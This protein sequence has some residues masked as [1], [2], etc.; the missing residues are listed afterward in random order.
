M[1][2]L[3]DKGVGEHFYYATETKYADFQQKISMEIIG[4]KS[5][6]LGIILT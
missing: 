6:T 1:T 2:T 3:L 5:Q 4:E